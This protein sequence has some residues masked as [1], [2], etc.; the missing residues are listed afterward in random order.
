MVLLNV[1]SDEE[2]S[3][4]WSLKKHC[5]C[6]HTTVGHSPELHASE[7]THHFQWATDY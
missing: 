6:T 7:S 1:K 5:A 2:Q 4:S 3:F